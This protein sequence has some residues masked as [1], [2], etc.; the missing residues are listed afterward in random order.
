[1]FAVRIL[2]LVL[3]PIVS[4]SYFL[5]VTRPADQKN[6]RSFHLRAGVVSVGGGTTNIVVDPDVDMRVDLLRAGGQL[7]PCGL[8][9]GPIEVSSPYTAT[10]VF[11]T[12]QVYFDTG[13][14]WNVATEL[15]L[16]Q[17]GFPLGSECC[18]T[19]GPNHMK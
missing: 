1:M 8:P 11:N 19:W 9:T 16:Q 6:G 13:S 17:L 4:G 7:A 14:S 12:Y 10:P 15:M 3:V 5:N 18:V 2:L